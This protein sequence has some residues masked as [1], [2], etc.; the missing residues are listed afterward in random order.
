M[1]KTSKGGMV[2]AG[3]CLVVQVGIIVHAHKRMADLTNGLNGEPKLSY[4]D[5]YRRLIKK[6]LKK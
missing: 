4:T 2:V 3:I 1:E 6:H 5:H